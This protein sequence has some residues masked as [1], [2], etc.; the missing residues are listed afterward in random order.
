VAG[1]ELADCQAGH[2]VVPR[3]GDPRGGRED[4]SA[5]TELAVGD[6]Q[7]FA[8]PGAPAPQHDI[9]IEHPGTPAR[10][11]AAAAEFAFD[12]L[13]AI[14]QCLG[15]EVAGQDDRRIGISAAGGTERRAVLHRGDRL[16][17]QS[18]LRHRCDRRADDLARPAV[19]G[20]AHVGPERDQVTVRQT[21][22]QIRP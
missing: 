2:G 18:C 15:W 5:G 1:G 17:R 9:E 14:E 21:S 19:P 4:E 8:C 11:S 16:Q 22:S 13:Q 10:A 7:A 6:N 12:P 3:G 20:V